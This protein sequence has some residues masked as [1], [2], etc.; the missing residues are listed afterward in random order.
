MDTQV[1][2]QN[3]N[4]QL[5]ECEDMD[6]LHKATNNEG[7]GGTTVLA[8]GT[9]YTQGARLCLQTAFPISALAQL[10]KVKHGKNKTN[11]P[12]SVD[13]AKDRVNRPLESNH[14]NTI[15]R[16]VGD[17][18]EDNKPYILPSLTLNLDHP[19]KVFAIG[20]TGAARLAIMALPLGIPLEITDGQ[21]RV[22]G[23]RRALEKIEEE[24]G[25]VKDAIGVMITFT[26]D[27]SQIH[28]DFADCAKTKAISDSL[29]AVYD[30]R[31][32]AN[33]LVLDLAEQ[34]PLFTHTVDAIKTVISP[35]TVAAWSTNNL[36]IMLKWALFGKQSGEEVFVNNAIRVLNERG[37]DAYAEFLSSLISDI[38]ILTEE[39]ST[40]KK[41]AALNTSDL[42]RIPHI[43]ESDK[44]LIMTGSGLAVIG[45]LWYWL[46]QA[47]KEYPGFDANARL[48]Q[49]ARVNWT[50]DSG[51]FKDN[52]R[53]NPE[54]RSSGA[55]YI[56]GAATAIWQ[57]A[58]PGVKIPGSK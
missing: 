37:S 56:K 23:V 10:V 50:E 32:P 17:A 36:R 16:Y 26:A 49:I 14:A 2:T 42:S 6:T 24:T 51:L 28:Q 35:R 1:N 7:A 40:L 39:N 29:L 52:L 43:R 19:V 13:S 8:V 48:V 15:A 25:P 3:A 55:K 53:I 20:E 33:G 12:T 4:I 47:K 45:L 34:C 31:N 18:L 5:V 38:A 44:S 54:R 41:L 30:R 57:Q 27:K 11:M 58:C 22:E 46:T 21:H 9:L